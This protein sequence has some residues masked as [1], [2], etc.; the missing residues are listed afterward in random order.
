MVYAWS[1]SDQDWSFGEGA[2]I[3][4]TREALMMGLAARP[5]LEDLS[6]EGLSVWR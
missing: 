1:A 6:G 4:G 3:T 5:V 2:V